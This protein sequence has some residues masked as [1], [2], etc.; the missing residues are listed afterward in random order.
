MTDLAATWAD[1][2]RRARTLWPERIAE[3]ISAAADT[4]LSAQ[5]F[6]GPGGRTT[7]LP[8][9]EHETCDDGPEP[10]SHL[11]TSDPTGNTVVRGL[12]RDR[13]IDDLSRLARASGDFVAAAGVVLDWVCGRRPSDWAGVVLVSAELMPGS[14]SAGLD[15]DHARRLPGA[16]ATVE[17]AVDTVEAIAS[18][19][20]PRAPSTDEQHWTA[21]LADEDCCAWHLAIHRR[22]RR[23]KVGAFQGERICADCM[24]L[25]LLGEERP[26]AWLLEAEVDRMG[27]PMAW[28]LALGRWLDELGVERERSA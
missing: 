8:C 16:I 14:I 9:R 6:G 26:P 24:Q 20:L 10:H 12:R 2:M 25:V 11:V 27:K 23:P 7:R 19:H 18:D 15:V 5:R 22:Y 3:R 28:Q 1:A 13:S 17:R 21:G 4:G